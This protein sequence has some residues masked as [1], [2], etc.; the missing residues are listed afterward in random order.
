[1]TTI[2]AK[3]INANGR[4][5]FRNMP[6]ALIAFAV[7]VVTHYLT[8]SIQSLWILLGSRIVIAAALYF[9]IMKT[10]HAKILDECIQ[11][12]RKKI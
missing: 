7:M 6:F 5:S 11:F 8:S 2:T 3:A 1:M 12:V 9:I 4:V 10:A